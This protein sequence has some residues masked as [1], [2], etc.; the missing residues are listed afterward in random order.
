MYPVVGDPLMPQ[1]EA[2]R[3]RLVQAGVDC[4]WHPVEGAYHGYL[5]DA[6]DVGSYR[7][8]TMDA[9]LDA[10]PRG[11]IDTAR[12]VLRNSLERALGPAVADIP[13]DSGKEDA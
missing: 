4:P 8:Q 5:E 13:F 12:S 2:M 3:E 10:R 9:T 11:F 6:A 7:A 1:A